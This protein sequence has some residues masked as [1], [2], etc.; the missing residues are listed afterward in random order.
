M[1]ETWPSK[2][3]AWCPG[4]GNF[5]ILKTLD[6]AVNA[7]GLDRRK[8]VLVSGIGQAAKTPH[9]LATN[10]FNGLHGRAV[11]AAFDR[12]TGKFLYYKHAANKIQGSSWIALHE[13]S[14]TFFM[15][16]DWGV[17]GYRLSSGDLVDNRAYAKPDKP[18]VP[19]GQALAGQTLLKGQDSVQSEAVAAP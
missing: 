12:H 16:T 11:P 8:L 18:W 19:T 5:S 15:N 17:H 1:I 14:D 13:Q 6:E 10:V 3:P 9:Y 2:T 4:C 7:V